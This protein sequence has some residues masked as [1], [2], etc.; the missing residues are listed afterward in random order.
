MFQLSDSDQAQLLRVARESVLAYLSGRAPRL[1]VLTGALAD[2]RGVFVSIHQNGELRGCIGNIH[3][4]SPLYRT[5]GDCAISAAVGDPRF[6]PITLDE[7]P[8]VHFEISVLSPMEKVEK[9]DH[10]EIGKHG[11][12]ISKRSARG[13]LL[14]QVA[15]HYG[16]DRERFLA[17]T[18]RKAGLSPEDWK[19]DTG[20]FRFTAHVFGEKVAKSQEKS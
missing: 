12:F 19:S 14:P 3:P 15:Q 8:R 7:L 10:I 17:E 18:C 13:L 6:V 4:T 2:T 16:W 20:I 5:A 1:P 11:L 9:V